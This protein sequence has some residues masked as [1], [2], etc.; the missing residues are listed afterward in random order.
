MALSNP[1]LNSYFAFTLCMIA[2]HV[3]LDNR[4]GAQGRNWL[5]FMLPFFLAAII[6]APKALSLPH[7]REVFSQAVLTGL[8]LFVGLGIHYGPRTIRQRFYGPHHGELVAT[9]LEARLVAVNDVNWNGSAGHSVTDDPQLVF[10]IPRQFV[11]AVR[12]RLAMQKSGPRD[13]NLQAFWMRS[14][15]NT[16]SATERTTFVPTRNCTQTITI[17]INDTIDSL[18][19]DP[20]FAPCHFQI[21]EMCL[22]QPRQVLIARR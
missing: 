10:Q 21:Q 6:Y 9:P 16:F 14:G 13:G 18:R 2:L 3:W 7:V 8:L 4:F 12:L 19:I 1:V 17:W 5:P 15:E 20:A 11:H 22:L